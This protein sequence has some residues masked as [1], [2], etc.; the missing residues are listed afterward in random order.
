MIYWVGGL[1]FLAVIAFLWEKA[2]RVEAEAAVRALQVD[3]EAYL[4]RLKDAAATQR[5]QLETLTYLRDEAKR[6]SDEL[7]TCSI[8]DSARTRLAGV[9][10]RAS[11]PRVF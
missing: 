6:L 7:E 1:G 8:P 9:L 2:A 4:H 10:A 5:R 11:K 3:V